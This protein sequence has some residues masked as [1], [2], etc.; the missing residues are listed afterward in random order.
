MTTI[1]DPLAQFQGR[2][3][4]A[5]VALLLPTISL[6]FAFLNAK[7]GLVAAVLAWSLFG[8]SVFLCALAIARYRC[9]FCGRFPEPEIPL[10]NPARCC[11]CG[12]ALRPGVS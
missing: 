9:P 5:L 8:I 1:R 3:R 11:E 4:L 12:A 6:L 7:V 10:F 2:R